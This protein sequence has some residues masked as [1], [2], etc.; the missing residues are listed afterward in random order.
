LSK[1]ANKEISNAINAKIAI[2]GF[3][4]KEDRINYI[5]LSFK[6]ISITNRH[7]DNWL[8]NMKSLSAKRVSIQPLT[9]RNIL[10]KDWLP[11]T[12][13]PYLFTYKN[14]SDLSMPNATNA[15]DGGL[16]TQLKKLMK[17]HQGIS[18]S[19][20]AKLIIDDY[21]AYYNNRL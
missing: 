7:C 16:F 19:L 15:L 12:N 13:L 2:I 6:S 20:K 18:R 9:K 21:L 17:P 10:I 1:K 3:H 14:H 4:Q 5:K 8:Q 11:H